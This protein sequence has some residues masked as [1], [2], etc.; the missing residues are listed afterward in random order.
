VVNLFSVAD[1]NG[2]IKIFTTYPKLKPV[3]GK[4]E[5]L[6]LIK[7]QNTKQKNNYS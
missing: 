5:K 2:F 7:S 6:N 3:K 4:T 1:E